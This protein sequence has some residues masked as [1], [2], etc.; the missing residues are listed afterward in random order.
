MC[1]FCEGHAPLITTGCISGFNLDVGIF[2]DK[3]VAEAIYNHDFG[4]ETV[5]KACVIKYCP[6]CGEKIKER[7]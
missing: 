4:D 3:V 2:G 7:S 1:N 5:T 6:M